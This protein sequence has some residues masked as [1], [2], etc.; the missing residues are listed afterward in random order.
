M[1][2]NTSSIHD[3]LHYFCRSCNTFRKRAFPLFQSTWQVFQEAL[4]VYSNVHR[5]NGIYSKLSTEM[6][7]KA[8]QDILTCVNA[9]SDLYHLLFVGSQQS[10]INTIGFNLAKQPL[11][12]IHNIIENNSSNIQFDFTESSIALPRDDE[13]YVE[14][15]RVMADVRDNKYS[16]TD[17]FVLRS[18]TN[19]FH[20]SQDLSYLLES[21]YKKNI[22]VVLIATYE[23]LPSINMANKQI[24]HLIIC[25]DDIGAP[26]GIEGVI[27]KK[28]LLQKE[29]PFEVGG[30]VVSEIYE[31]KANYILGAEVGTPNIIGAIALSHALQRMKAEIKKI[32]GHIKMLM[33]YATK[34][35]S[36]FGDN[37]FRKGRDFFTVKLPYTASVKM[38]DVEAE[39]FFD[40]N[41]KRNELIFHLNIDNTI[42]DLDKALDILLCKLNFVE[43]GQEIIKS[44]PKRVSS[45][46]EIL[47]NDNC[48]HFSGEKLRAMLESMVITRKSIPTA[49][50][51]RKYVNLD[52]AASTPTFQPIIDAIDR[53]LLLKHDMQRKTL[54][55]AAK[56]VEEFFH[57][58]R[59]SHSIL[60]GRNT[61]EMINLFARH[62]DVSEHDV[63]I[64]TDAE[65]NSNELP[66]RY[67]KGIVRKRIL[68]NRH[69]ALDLWH[70][71]HELKELKSNVENNK[72]RILV[73]ISGASNVL[74]N[75]NDIYRIAQIV[76]SYNGQIF[77]D[78]AQLSAHRSIFLCGKNDIANSY[79]DYYVFSGHKMYAPFG[80][81][82][83]IVRNESRQSFIPRL[84]IT[85]DVVH[86]NLIGLIALAKS[87]NLLGRI[88]T[89]NIIQH[90]KC[91]LQYA[92]EKLLTIRGVCLYGVR[93][94][95]DKKVEQGC[96][97]GIIPFNIMMYSRKHG[98]HNLSTSFVASVLSYE[99]GIGVREGC[100]C[101]NLL[102]RR[103]RRYGE[104]LNSKNLFRPAESFFSYKKGVDESPDGMIRISFG[105]YNT[106]NEI[107]R[108]IGILRNLTEGCYFDEYARDQD[109]NWYSSKFEQI[110]AEYCTT[111]SNGI[112]HGSESKIINTEY[113]QNIYN[114]SVKNNERKLVMI[115]QEKMQ[116]PMK[117]ICQ[118]IDV[119]K[120]YY[121][122][123]DNTVTTQNRI[124]EIFA[125]NVISVLV[126]QELITLY[127]HKV[128]DSSID[129]VHI[130]LNESSEPYLADEDS[131]K[132]TLMDV[133]HHNCIICSM[134]FGVKPNW[135]GSILQISPI[136]SSQTF[137][138]RLDDCPI[139]EGHILINTKTH[140]TSMASLMPQ[141]LRELEDL[142]RTIKLLF[143]K[144]YSKDV[145]FFEHGAIGVCDSQA[146]LCKAPNIHSS[147]N[148][149]HLHAIPVD[150]SLSLFGERGRMKSN[151]QILN[152][153]QFLNTPNLL[154][155]VK[156]NNLM[157]H[158]YIYVQ[159][160][161][162][163]EWY[164]IN[165]P[166]KTSQIMRI[167]IALALG[168]E[169]QGDWRNG[170]AT[171]RGQRIYHEWVISAQ[172]KITKALSY[173][174]K[175]GYIVGE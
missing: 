134:I 165:L 45:V 1:Q 22:P 133:A 69:G 169:E 52:N 58:D 158:K 39:I 161:D 70:L 55:T 63:I 137:M 123:I 15:N 33:L 10:S 152:S 4:Q 159:A 29:K 124:M 103:F 160:P 65:H 110:Y 95:N 54:N 154:D 157:T 108:I 145:L 151:N 86:K 127:Y 61:S 25:G 93:D 67:V 5:G 14:L 8:R 102:V 64:S 89:D 111:V 77:V 162:D 47:Q 115:L 90:E 75:V 42:Y 175:N 167:A 3:K 117:L 56:M 130:L 62:L 131:V 147:I 96:Y 99:G 142:K 2:N 34:A 28:K 129:S 105:L 168:H 116:L 135:F 17:L 166:E 26:F 13:G 104:V 136:F 83:L 72:R 50:G 113:D 19:E 31:N 41:K 172:N 144:I 118:F 87:V 12:V 120:N 150:S 155:A 82:G 122:F 78:G 97:M 170:V 164:A 119:V 44:I 51:N 59:H 92:L 94:P 174:P 146:K 32:D 73:A 98:M 132:K 173:S 128:D 11:R 126:Y 36:A 171:K 68:V 38:I 53:F 81:G 148:H 88:G 37:S 43:K 153:I 101:A 143:N 74:G 57:I 100:F 109:G 49:H 125:G 23:I 156:K 84:K 40:I 139:T 24:D 76:H 18:G 6:M 80:I 7:E 16:V 107:D 106:K 9:S 140:V 141:Q 60:Y 79:I 91:L 163:T 112:L 85:H 48:L 138:V 46:E 114:S 121:D 66:W 35:F 20:S 71:E 21:L 149:A 30:G 27:I